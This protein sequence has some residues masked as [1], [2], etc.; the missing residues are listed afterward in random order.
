MTVIPAYDDKVAFGLPYTIYAW[1]RQW[2]YKKTELCVSQL[3]C[4]ETVTAQQETIIYQG[5]KCKL[6]Q[7][8]YCGS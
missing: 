5:Q 2:T 6:T 8:F 4:W 3:Q 7:R 1:P